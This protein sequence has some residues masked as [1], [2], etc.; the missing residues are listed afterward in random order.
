MN[1]KQVNKKWFLLITA[2]LLAAMLGNLFQ[3]EAASLPTEEVTVV[4]WE[5]DSKYGVSYGY[6]VDNLAHEAVAEIYPDYSSA[7][8]IYN[9]RDFSHKELAALLKNLQPEELVPL[10]IT[11]TGPLTKDEFTDFVRK[12]EIVADKYTIFLREPDGK[13]VTVQGS[14]DENGVLIPE[15]LLAMAMS[16]VHEASG[17]GTEFL[18]WVD[19]SGLVAAKVIPVIA[20]DEDVFL[21][22]G[23]EAVLQ[24]SLT[25]FRLK[26]AHIPRA[27]RRDVLAGGFASVGMPPT[28][29]FLYDYGL[30]EMPGQQN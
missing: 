14:P 4:Y 16:G 22:D 15:S 18:G 12:Y 5:T 30:M 6:G 28:A 21:A 10:K 7:E 13:I 2:F 11:F 24:A 23:M 19:V 26:E 3:Q 25:D 1:S 27:V 20:G 29:S 17:V 9:Y 8:G